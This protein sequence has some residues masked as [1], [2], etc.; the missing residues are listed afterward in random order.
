MERGRIGGAGEAEAD[1]AEAERLDYDRTKALAR[2]GDVSVRRALAERDD[3]KPEILYFLA[4][5]ATPEVRRSVAANPTAPRQADAVLARD[6]DGEVREVLAGKIAKLAPGLSADEQ[7]KMRRLTYDVL[8]ILV[9][10]ELPRV[11]R[12]IAETL[13]EIADAPPEIVRRLACDGEISVAAPM[14]ACSPTLTDEDLLEIIRSKPVAGAL[15]AISRRTGV[16][17]AVVDAIVAA[18]DVEAVALLLANSSAQI[19][20]QTLDKIA[21]RAAD[22]EVWHAPL[23]RRPELSRKAATRIARFVA[24]QLLD[25]LARRADLPAATMQAVR[26]AVA[27]RVEEGESTAAP[28]RQKSISAAPAEDPVQAARALHVKG[29]LD[30]AR[31]LEAV[32][33]GDRGFVR[34]ALG[35]RSGLAAGIVEK[36]FSTRSAKGVTA[37][38]WKA[39]LSAKA[40]E[41]IQ[42]A[43]AGVPP[44]EVV[45]ARVEGGFT[46]SPEDLTWQVEFLAELAGKGP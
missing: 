17:A 1:G 21:A 44:R 35:V 10:D 23:V 36:A 37:L 43:V 2:D 11:R 5:D 25:E 20:E 29:K 42:I 19:R 41:Q 4:E 34:A 8:E 15:A 33:Q 39:G 14:L 45:R 31:V 13:K 28:A 7:D 46:L 32:R 3:L 30:E 22:I 12:I 6:A 40:A 9:K 27:R 24:K 18:D 38:A 16:R 26:E